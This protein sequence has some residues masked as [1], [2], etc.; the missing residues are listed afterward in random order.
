MKVLLQTLLFFLLSISSAFAQ[1]LVTRA[2]LDI[3]SGAT[4]IKVARV[5][6]CEQKII[7]E[8]LDTNL[9]VGYKA[10]LQKS[11][12]NTFSKEIIKQGVDAIES[13]MN[14]ARQLGATEF[15]AVTTS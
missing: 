2:G 13:L 7:E 12:D 8:L 6:T 1:C 3:G 15:F 10:D 9:P 11:K 5:N 4:K 14:Q